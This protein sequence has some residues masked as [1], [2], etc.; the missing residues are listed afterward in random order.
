MHAA[1]CPAIAI[2]KQTEA[3]NCAQKYALLVLWTALPRRLARG[4]GSLND[5]EL[6]NLI[7]L[8][9]TVSIANLIYGQCEFGNY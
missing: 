9:K 5:I 8:K 3:V 6:T 1:T 2:T 4:P 7:T